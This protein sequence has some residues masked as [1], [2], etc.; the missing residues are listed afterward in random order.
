MKKL[1]LMGT[2]LAFMG[3]TSLPA[4]ARP[5]GSKTGK[6]TQS[7]KKTGSK[8]KPAKKVRRAA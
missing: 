3:A 5:S 6:Q 1:V 2:L 8:H 4:A 7:K